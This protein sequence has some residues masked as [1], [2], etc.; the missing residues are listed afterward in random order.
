MIDFSINNSSK[1]L[2]NYIIVV[3][4]YMLYIEYCFL[5]T[6]SVCRIQDKQRQKLARRLQKNCKR[7]VLCRDG[8]VVEML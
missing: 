6:D 8:S 2:R 7:Q 3:Y 1:D 4:L 5:N